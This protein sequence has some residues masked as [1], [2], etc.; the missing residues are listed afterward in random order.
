MRIMNVWQLY[1]ADCARY[2]ALRPH[3]SMLTIWLTEQGLWALMQYRL[4]S[5][6]YRSSLPR[7]VKSPL[8][9]IM[10]FWQ[11]VIEVITKISLPYRTQIGHGL[12][13]G[14]CGPII[15]HP[16]VVIGHDCN[17]SQVTT[18]GISGMGDHRGVPTIG[19]RVF[20]GPHTVIVGPITVGN[21]TVIGA[22]AI[23]VTSVRSNVTVV[24]N[25]AREVSHQ[26]SDGYVV[27]AGQSPPAYTPK[28]KQNLL[29]LFRSHNDEYV[30]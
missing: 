17:L 20:I 11:V 19:D 8:L 21:D 10:V 22:G 28:D 29:Q 4:A 9:G 27:L 24:G 23:V 18:I 16:D 14:H 13:I 3:H 2:R 30:L 6:I 25:P 15:L 26:G 5:K 12:Y 1:R 7:G